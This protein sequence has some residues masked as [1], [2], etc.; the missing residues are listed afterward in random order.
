MFPPEI[1]QCMVELRPL[2]AKLL[3]A[4]TNSQASVAQ[5]YSWERECAAVNDK[6]GAL[7]RQYGFPDIELGE[8]AGEAALRLSVLMALLRR[9][10]GGSISKTELLERIDTLKDLYE[11]CETFASRANSTN[12]QLTFDYRER[13]AQLTEFEQ[14]ID[15]FM[16]TQTNPLLQ[17]ERAANRGECYIAT[18]VYGSYDAPSVKTLR[19]YRDERLERSALGRAFVRGYYRIS[20]PLAR[21]FAVDSPLSRAT[22]LLLDAI[23]RRLESSRS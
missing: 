12:Q 22:R 3:E 15:K 6:M 14:N 10:P 20:P 1:E 16:E 19:R 23:V 13:V 18:A 11:T 21:Y 4:S 9:A 2:Q 8:A 17:G 7:T 5:I